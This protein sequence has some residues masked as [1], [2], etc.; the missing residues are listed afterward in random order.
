MKDSLELTGRMQILH[1]SLL[2]QPDLLDVVGEIV[3]VLACQVG[4]VGIEMSSRMK[5]GKEGREEKR[6]SPEMS[7]RSILS[8]AQREPQ[9]CMSMSLAGIGS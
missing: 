7:M 4:P 5:G 8:T 3:L 1:P 6:S 2:V 9:V